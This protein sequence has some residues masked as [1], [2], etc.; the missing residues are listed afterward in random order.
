[1]HLI[2]DV[3]CKSIIATNIYNYLYGSTVWNT[4][5]MPKKGVFV[6]SLAV[7]AAFS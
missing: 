5:T 2:S 4:C 7:S 3:N 1:M 6:S